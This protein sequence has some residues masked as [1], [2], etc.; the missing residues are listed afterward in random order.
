MTD[1]GGG[2]KVTGLS[3]EPRQDDS[4]QTTVGRVLTGAQTSERH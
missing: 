2:T 1:R 4:P 3:Q